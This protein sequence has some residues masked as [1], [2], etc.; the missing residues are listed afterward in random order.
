[1]QRYDLFKEN[2]FG[3]SD[4]FD[5]LARHRFGQKANKVTGMA[6][7]ERNPDFTVGLEA[8]NAGAVPCARVHHDEWPASW[9]NLHTPWRHNMHKSVIDR[10]FQ[11]SA[12]DH[13]L[14]G[15][16]KDMGR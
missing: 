16:A 11:R 3:S 15:I 9:I 10:P 7:F 1:M 8:A 14:D 5:G 13:Q 6:C 4:I 2:G 12:I